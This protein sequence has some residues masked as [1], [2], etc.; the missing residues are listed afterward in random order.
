MKNNIIYIM[1]V[2]LVFSFSLPVYG[3]HEVF[4][5]PPFEEQ[6]GT[7][8]EKEEMELIREEVDVEGEYKMMDEDMKEMEK[9]E[10]KRMDPW[11][12]DWGEEPKYD[13]ENK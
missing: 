3:G 13:I 9:E 12:R 2:I 6:R 11:Y 5:P 7:A 4:F 1:S 8:Q 10:D